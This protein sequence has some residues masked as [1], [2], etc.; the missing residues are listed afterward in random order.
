M[1]CEEVFN[2][3][4]ETGNYSDLEKATQIAKNMVTKHGMSNLGYAQ[5]AH[6]DDMAELVH[7]EINVILNECY[8]ETKKII[9]D[10][11]KTIA[12]LAR[13]L[14]EKKEITGEEFMAKLKEIESHQ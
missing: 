5:I 4:F 6:P 12:L 8:L 3:E 10:N 7:K 14:L 11:Q 13:F 2:G 1:C 9:T